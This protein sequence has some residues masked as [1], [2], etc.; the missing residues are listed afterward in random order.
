MGTDQTETSLK[1]KD[2]KEVA[3]SWAWHS[4]CKYGIRAAMVTY[5]VPSE[6]WVC[7]QSCIHPEGC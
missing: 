7:W 1:G 3:N 2:R 6:A 5:S 4:H